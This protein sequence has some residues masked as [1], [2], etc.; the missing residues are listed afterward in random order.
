MTEPRIQPLNPL[1]LPLQGVRLI[2]ASAGTGKTFTIGLLYLRLLLGTGKDAARDTPLTPEE[3]LV[4]TFTESATAELRGRIRENI[5]RLRLACLRG[6]SRDPVLSVLLTEISDCQQAADILLAAERQMDDAAIFT[7]HGFCQRMLNLNAFESGMLFEQQLLEDESALRRQAAADFW[8]CYCYSLPRDIAAHIAERWQGPEDLLRTLTPWL[9]GEMPVLK[10]APETE[11]TLLQRHERIINDINAMKAAWREASSEVAS[12]INASGADKRSYSS[13]HLPGW[14]EKINRWSQQPAEDYRVPKELGRFSQA[15]LQEKTKKGPPPQHPLFI[16]I[17]A[18]LAQSLSLHDLL[19]ARA[20]IFI[21]ANMQQEKRFRAQLGFDDLLSR[22][23]EALQRSGGEVLAAR[24]RQRFP[25]ALIDEFQDTDPQ[26]YRIFHTLYAD[27]PSCALLLIGDPKQAIYAFRGAD[28]FTYMKARQEVSA[29]YTLDTNWRSSPAMVSAVNQLFSACANPFLFSALSFLPVASAPAKAAMRFTLQGEPQPAMR[30]W[31]QPGDGVSLNEYQTFMARQCATQV[32]DWL[33]AGQRGE[34]LLENGKHSQAVSAADIAI[35]V[36]S[37]R[38]AALIRDALNRYHIPA[39]YLSSRDSVFTV[40][41][42]QELAW[43]LQAVLAPEQERTLRCAIATSLFGLTAAALEALNQDEQAWDAL[44]DEFRLYHQHWQRRGILPM[45]R[46]VMHHHRI[47]ENLLAT[48]GGERR[49]TDI[50]HLSELLQE[51]AGQFDSEAALVRWLNQQIARPDMQSASQQLRLESD[52][53][54]VKIITIHKAKGLEYPLVWLPFAAGFREAE[55]GLYHDPISGEA[56]LDLHGSEES[57]T[58][59]EQERQA[60]DLRLLYV[61]LTR[62]VWH[63]SIGIAPVFRGNRKKEGLSDVAKSAL[64]WLVGGGAA[65]SAEALQLALE[66]LQQHDGIDFLPG[67][68]ADD[69][70]WQPENDA[71]PVLRSA[72]LTRRIQDD[73]RVTSYSALQQHR[74]HHMLD[75]LPRL[76]VDAAGETQIVSASLFTPHTFPRGAAPGT[77]LH[78]LL[79]A[80]DFTQSPDEAWLA[81]KLAL[82]GMASHWLPIMRDWLQTILCAPLGD[83]GASLQQLHATDKQAE[84]AFWLPIQQRLT[85]ERVTAVIS[86]YDM[87]SAQAGALNF[88]QVQGMLKGFIDLVFRWQGKYYLL[89]YKSNWLGEEGSAYTRQAMSQAMIT[90]RYDLQYQLYTLALHRYLR[91]RLPDY[92]YQHHFGGVFYLFLRG[93]DKRTP[94]QGVWYIKPDEALVQ[95]L[96]ALFQGEI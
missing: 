76:D 77:F 91:H 18:F 8:R 75:L 16:R 80:L 53:H 36:R 46:E 81:E 45:L 89:D 79:E 11:E 7:I 43:L 42:A 50:L 96:D 90:H 22:L 63:C 62:S 4:V 21:R 71:M 59:A 67:R 69:A 31:L 86:Q 5:H 49:L 82:Q 33:L 78:S 35:L 57:R 55:A 19:I 10:P 95:Q 83:S 12:L 34:L 40:P 54:L 73:W 20:L 44:V 93:I 2:E 1:T 72:A 58:Y 64:G 47:A 41:E 87:L 17:D 26:Q 27:Q 70:L 15:Q 51:A 6:Y 84:L 66:N 30:F 60:E 56:I 14:I 3:I 13:R 68:G 61:A 94:G 74:H 48:A 28:I 38:E 24:I 23:D 39:V 32:R 85:A 37:R 9:Q 29:H 88:Y 65:L 25:V 52:K 92:D